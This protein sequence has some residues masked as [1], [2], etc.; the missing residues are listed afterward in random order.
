MMK[1]AVF[2][3]VKASGKTALFKRLK[4]NLFSEQY[5]PGIGV[6]HCKLNLLTKKNNSEIFASIILSFNV[7]V[8]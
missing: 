5:M 7:T 8:S 3:G 1:G 2:V 6:E 4:E